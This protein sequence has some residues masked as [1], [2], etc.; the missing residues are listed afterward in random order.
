MQ[1][2]TSTPP[3]RGKRQHHSIA[4]DVATI[5]AALN[6]PTKRALAEVAL[7]ISAE[8]VERPTATLDEPLTERDIRAL[9]R[10]GVTPEPMNDAEFYATEPVH[11]GIAHR[12]DVTA[13]A[14][15]LAEAARRVG[16]S[17]ARLRQRI[18]DGTLAAIRRPR[19]RGWLVPVFQ[20]TDTGELPHLARVL[21]ATRREVSPY[22]LDAVF[23]NPQEELDGETP[24]GWLM[25]DRDPA[26]VARIL[27]GL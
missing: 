26:A 12:A 21:A 3:V 22:T 24:R 5:D 9:A 16:V 20:L 18:S 14:I 10:I 8:I 6:D 13:T 17:D 19:G 27:A 25:A 7:R 23:R 1:H 11:Q 4:R 2:P 15:P